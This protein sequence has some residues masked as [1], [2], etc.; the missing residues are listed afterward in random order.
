[1]LGRLKLSLDGYLS[2]IFFWSVDDTHQ[3]NFGCKTGFD[4]PGGLS[5]IF[6]MN[7]LYY[8]YNL[9][10][11]MNGSLNLGIDLKMEF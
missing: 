5:L 2:N 7:Q 1:M 10:G 8:D 6:D 11:D 3:M 9:N 4:L